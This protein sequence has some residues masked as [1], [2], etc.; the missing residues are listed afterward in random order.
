MKDGWR[1]LKAFIVSASVDVIFR[2]DAIIFALGKIKK[3]YKIKNAQK[4][5]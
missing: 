4:C 5:K 2:C 3:N 1:H